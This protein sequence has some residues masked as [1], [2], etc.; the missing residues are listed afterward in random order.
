MA[1]LLFN[2]LIL[3]LALFVFGVTVFVHEL[4]HFLV[5]RRCGLII[6]TFSIGFGKALVKWEKD[7]IAYQIGWIPFGGYVALPQLDPAGMDKIQG[8]HSGEPYTEISPFCGCCGR[9][10]WKCAFRDGFSAGD[11]VD[12]EWRGGH[13]DSTC[14]WE[15]RNQ[16]CG[17]RRRIA[18]G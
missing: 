18:R 17:V 9:S 1:D 12:S 13:S 3:L 8:E 4:G 16:Q 11:L 6:K 14:G 2:G 7:G 15:H 5:A 10:G